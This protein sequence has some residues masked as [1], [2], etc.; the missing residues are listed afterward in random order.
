M[1]FST[2]TVLDGILSA[3]VL[4]GLIIGLI[5]GFFSTISIPAKIIGSAAI[6]YCVANPVIETWTRPFFVEKAYGWIN[7]LLISKCPDITGADAGEK[8]PLVL[9]LVAG[10]FNIDVS[11]LGENATTSDLIAV[12][13]ESMSLPVGNLIATAVTYLAIFVII[14]LLFSIVTAII[15]GFVS[16][17]PLAVVDKVLGML[18][19]T[20]ISILICSIAA[21]IISGVAPDLQGGF[22]YEFFKNF[23]PFSLILSI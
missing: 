12:I 4:V 15:G 1:D 16:S 13:A 22:V 23:D 10:M 8:L 19:G 21:N 2:L 7:D 18:L 17:G 11:A 3:A 14:F 20:A 6:T 5:K 9:K